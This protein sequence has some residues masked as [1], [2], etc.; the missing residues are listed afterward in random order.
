MP[1]TARRR[2]FTDLHTI[3]E[4]LDALPA[5]WRTRGRGWAAQGA[6][7]HAALAPRPQRVVIGRGSMAYAASFAAH[8]AVERGAR[9]AIVLDPG[10]YDG[11]TPAEGSWSDATVIA[12]SASGET[13]DVTRCAVHLRVHGAEVVGVTAAPGRAPLEDGCDHLLRLELGPEGPAS[14]GVV[15]ASFVAAAALVG[16]RAGR[17]A[18]EAADDL[19][20]ALRS[21]LPGRVAERLVPARAVAWVGDGA[22]HPVACEAAARLSQLAQMPSVALTTSELLHGAAGSLSRAD[23]VVLLAGG[24]EPTLPRRALEAQLRGRRVE[25]V[26]LGDRHHGSLGEAPEHL[27]ELSGPLWTTAPV[28]LA[29][30]QR[31]ACDVALRRGAKP[32]RAIRAHPDPA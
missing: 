6:Q 18:L 13:G 32:R 12:F 27:V 5:E 31:V 3:R 26:R 30:A 14:V 20:R 11:P 24:T 4:S 19:E 25:L 9:P 8:L 23:A 22:L 21:D 28:L 17:I 15:G 2:P 29:I 10:L 1:A 16:L 7:I